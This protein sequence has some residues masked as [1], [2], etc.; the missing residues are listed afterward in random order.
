MF[1]YCGHLNF[2]NQLVRSL[3][4]IELSHFT[5]ILPINV[6]F[7][8]SKTAVKRAVIKDLINYNVDF[9]SCSLFSGFTVSQLLVLSHFSGSVLLI[10][11]Q[12]TSR[13]DS[14]C[15]V[16]LRQFV[17]RHVTPLYLM[18]V[19]VSLSHITLRHFILCHVTSFCLTSVYI[20]KSRPLAPLYLTLLYVPTFLSLHVTMLLSLYDI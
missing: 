9:H 16:T 3:Q 11:V 12:M 1:E 18:L 6:V 2:F 5:L 8:L 17:S 13:Y 19:K 15:H 20:N 4:L 7:Y 14:L 10:S